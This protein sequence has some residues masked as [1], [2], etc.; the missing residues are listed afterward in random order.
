MD[1]IGV[2]MKQKIQIHKMF[3]E[4]NTF[5]LDGNFAVNTREKSV[6]WNFHVRTK[7]ILKG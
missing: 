1:K 7:G 2:Q 3:L 4:V 5:G 6:G